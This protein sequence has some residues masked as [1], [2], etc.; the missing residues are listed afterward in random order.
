MKV[1]LVVESLFGN[2][3]EVADAIASGIRSGGA[4]VTL[5]PAATAPDGGF[6]LVA[7]GAPTHNRGLPTPASRAQATA[8]GGSAPS[9][10]V[11]EWLDAHPRLAGA[12]LVAFDTVVPGL[13]SGSAAKRIAQLVARQGG[14]LVARESF[15]VGGSPPRLAPGEL[16]RAEG[17]GTTLVALAEESR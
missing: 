4:D 14:S 7:L 11:A 16:T 13:F 6:D 1:L 8:R 10:G 12:R 2:T 17:W 3:A 15:A 5:A 9:S